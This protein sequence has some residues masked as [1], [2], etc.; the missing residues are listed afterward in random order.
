MSLEKRK[1]RIDSVLEDFLSKM[2]EAPPEV[3]KVLD[4]IPTFVLRGGKRVRPAL[5]LEGYEIGGGENID[6]C[7]KA[8]LLIELCHNYFLMHDDVM[9][10]DE[11]RRGGP[12]L[13]K[14]YGEEFEEWTAISLAI[15]TGDYTQT[16]AL[17]SLLDS[18]FPKS[19]KYEVI[20]EYMRMQ[21]KVYIGQAL[22]LVLHETPLEEVDLDDVLRLHELK[23]ASYTISSPLKMGFLL[24]PEFGKPKSEELIEKLDR[25]GRKV[26]VAFQ[27]KDDL[28]GLYGSEEE[29]GKSVASDIEEGKRTIPL[30]IA[31]REGTRNQKDS[32]KSI[33]GKKADM[34]S[35]KSVRELVISTGAK[36][37]S[38]KMADEMVK[39]GKKAVQGLESDF[40]ES[41]ADF[42][43]ERSF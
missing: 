37:E 23:T 36:E 3:E 35:L 11:L 32:L 21:R 19:R 24:S 13:H 2:E 39:E 15:N 16:L 25:Y 5:F 29:I 17:Q 41:L 8:S 1:N 7:L 43:V 14:A 26:G 22:D 4:E 38:E 42:V 9:D 20:E 28:L 30:I 33:I 12:T 40:L 27:I 34:N 10:R 18:N 31:F 6:E